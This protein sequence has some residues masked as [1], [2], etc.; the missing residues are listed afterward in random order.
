[1]TAKLTKNLRNSILLALAVSA[2]T[3]TLYSMGVLQ[4]MEWMVYDRFV[5]QQRSHTRAPQDIA[6]ILIDDA[7]L[8]AMDPVVGRWPW[9]RS[10]FADVIDFL[11]LGEPQAL[12]FDL[13]FSERQQDNDLTQAPRNTGN[14]ISPNDRRLIS[15]T[16]DS[17]NTYHA[18]QFIADTED[19]ANKQLFNV[20][21]P[22]T[23]RQRFS[24]EAAPPATVAH[25]G[26]PTG[27]NTFLIPI[28]GL[29]QAAKGLGVVSVDEDRD[30]VLR[31]TRLLHTYGN[32]I[33][34]ALSIA[35]LLLAD[36]SGGQ[37]L[38]FNGKDLKKD[39]LT[40]P[41][42]RDN[43]FLLN[44]YGEYATY[45]MSG[46]LSSIAKLQAGDIEHLI[47]D[48]EEF[49]NKIILIGASAIGLHDLKTTAVADKIPGVFI[50]ATVMGNILQQDF[51]RPALRWQTW[52]SIV[53]TALLTAMGVFLNQRI[54]LQII[55]PLAVGTGFWWLAYWQFAHH[56][57]ME[58]MPA[59]AAILLSWACAYTYVLFTEEKEK[60]KI[61]RMFSQYVSPAALSVMVDQYEDYRSAGAGS[62]ETVSILFSD[63]RGFTT[64]SES[65]DAEAVVEILN[66]Y[67]STMTD[68]ILK[69]GGTVDK[70]IGDAIMAIWGAPI[71]TRT[72]AGDAVAAALEMRDKLKDI[73]EWMALKHY[74]P[75]DIG[76]GINTGE[77]VL[78]SIGS[79]QKA[80]YT[81]IGDNVNLASR[82]EGITKTYG[83]N[84]IIAETTY[85]QLETHIPCLLVDLVRV[86]GKHKPIRIYTPLGLEQDGCVQSREQAIEAARQSRLAFD[87]Y[88]KQEW[89]QAVRLYQ[90]LPHEQLRT[91]YLQR[92]AEYQH[93][94]PDPAWDG[95]FTMTSK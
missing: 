15:A 67:L 44:P 86:K 60:A 28:D 53:L 94:L 12:V 49:R 50:H 40:I 82:L 24:L 70:F 77:V 10:V 69:H 5:K 2:T 51:L 13:L 52:L 61:R 79:E 37:P 3:A 22:E 93:A 90:Q 73:N 43:S 6:I 29:Y 54:A 71:K 34:P 68:V 66:Y 7:S 39:K 95:A 58:V 65:L 59:F 62:K 30:G 47:V 23:I 14:V 56:Q 92:C 75:I 46:I 8:Q 19:D 38:R 83:C 63:I 26:R 42:T 78:G 81:V 18:M 87:H 84:T 35:P 55:L 41:L 17:G 11:S 4:R 36:K 32:E 48:P 76:I 72:H 88:M 27:Y 64:L 57:V 31:R 1:M 33:Y 9:P 45:S 21:L 89:E 80:D 85:Q 91:L 25:T 74:A 20:P 16:R